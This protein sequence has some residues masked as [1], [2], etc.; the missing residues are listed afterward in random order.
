MKRIILATVLLFTA[1]TVMASN[2]RDND[3]T[4]YLSSTLR[5]NWFVT[6]NGSVNWWQGS[7]RIPAGN[8]TTLNGPSFGGGVS[9]G[10]WITHNLALRLSYDVNPGKSFINGGHDNLSGL[11]FLYDDK[12]Q[13]IPVLHN[14]YLY[15][16]YKTTF[17][18]HNLHGDVMISPLD[19]IQK[20]SRNRRYT[21]VLVAGMGLACVSE[22]VFV[23]QSLL[24]GESRNFE[25]SFNGG[26]VSHFR[27]DKKNHFNLTLT[28]MVSGQQWKI[29]TWRYE[30]G[31]ETDLIGTDYIRP[32]IAD[33][34]YTIAL[35]ITWNSTGTEELGSRYYIKGGYYNNDSLIERIHDLEEDIKALANINDSLM[36]NPVYVHDTVIQFVE[37]ENKF[38]SIPFS[39]FF[40]LDS[41]HLK[42]R[43][44]WFNLEEIAKVAKE[45]HLIIHLRGSADSATATPAYNQALSERR[46]NMI[47]GILSSQ[48]G[49]PEVQIETEPVGG[50]HELDPTKFDRRVIV[51]LI[52]EVNP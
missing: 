48:M 31:G 33:F 43:G 15:Q 16:Y 6:V 51:T 49:V 21:P 52:K 34:N 50:V 4:R 39:I 45:H 1:I 47:K 44:D 32:R 42:S 28:T 24:H 23:T 20:E 2:G 41:H 5:E 26:L 7:D 9:V 37:G 25:L 30:Y 3:S 27:L 11:Q 29:D 17:M 8:F 22:H 40:E 46:C 36:G 12:T 19:L 10:K 38:V 13:P 35:G 14:G 18:Y